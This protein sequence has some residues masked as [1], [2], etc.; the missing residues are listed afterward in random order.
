MV[1]LAVMLHA[2]MPFYATYRP[3]SHNAATAPAAQVSSLLGDRILL[4]TASGFALVSLKDLLSGKAPVKPHNALMCAL[5]YVS[6]SDMGKL[7]VAALAWLA[8]LGLLA[9]QARAA[10]RSEIVLPA[11]HANNASPRAPPALGR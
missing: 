6:A 5:C 4:C 2:L 7:L 1:A 9:A 10:Q 11:P 8:C 3:A